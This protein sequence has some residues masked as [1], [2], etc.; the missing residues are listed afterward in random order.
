M[1]RSRGETSQRNLSAGI[2]GN[3]WLNSHYMQFFVG[4]FAAV[5]FLNVLDLWTSAIAMGQ[6]L[7]EG[8]GVVVDVAGLLGLQVLGGL[9]IM[10]VLAIAGGLAGAVLGIRAKDRQTRVLAVA[11]MLFL[12]MVLVV[13]SVNNIYAISTV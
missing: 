9:M 5:A 12:M 3:G 1:K 13:V 10:K 11:V 8:N 2:S 4:T 6:G 7:S